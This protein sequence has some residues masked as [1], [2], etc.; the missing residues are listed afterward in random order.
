M[1]GVYTGP[2]YS[3]LLSSLDYRTFSRSHLEHLSS[4][5]VAMAIGNAFRRAY[6]LGKKY[7][8]P[9][10]NTI[11][12]VRDG[13]YVHQ[14]R[15]LYPNQGVQHLAST[16]M[17]KRPTIPARTRAT[18]MVKQNAPS[19]PHIDAMLSDVDNLCTVDD[20]T[21]FF[22]KRAM[23]LVATKDDEAVSQQSYVAVTNRDFKTDVTM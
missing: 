4:T 1:A 5:G 9:V 18:Q 3:Q 8:P 6:T 17:K 19:T 20:N 10:V 16:T 13:M 14:K 21:P 7:I 23:V 22:I 2:E 12:D 11:R 15:P